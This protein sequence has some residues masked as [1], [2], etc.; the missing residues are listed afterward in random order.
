MGVRMVVRSCAIALIFAVA[1]TAHAASI[2]WSMP[3]DIANDSDVN[4]TGTL[5][6]A[7]NLVGATTV[8]NGVSFQSFPVGAQVNTIGG[9]SV[10]ADSG[11]VGSTGTGS[12]AIPFTNLSSEYR[13]MLS[14]WA[15]ASPLRLTMTN[16]TVGATYALQLWVN[17]A[18]SYKPPGFTFGVGIVGGANSVEL[19]PNTSVNEGGVGQYVIG[20]FTANSTTQEVSFDNGEVG[21]SLNGFQLRALV[22]PSQQAAPAMSPAMH[23][24][25]VL[26]L[27]AISAR[28][29]RQSVGTGA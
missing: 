19:D 1:G 16:L 4:L 28:R 27:L 14:D 9:F 13:T 24:I 26:A 7:F 5:V 29:L 12:A 18:R 10:A 23:T 17:D 11:S 3:A 22:V 20:T 25:L 21:G 8:I 2:N 6:G 15:D